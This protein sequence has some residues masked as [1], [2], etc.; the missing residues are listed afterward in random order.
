MTSKP[1]LLFVLLLILSYY[2]SCFSVAGDTLSAGQSLSVGDTLLSQGSKFELGFFSPGSSLK[3]YL[4]I[5]YKFY[6]DESYKNFNEKNAVWV[7]NRENPLS[8]PS[9][10]RLNLSEDGNLLL[11]GSSS[12][13]PF[14]STNLTFTGSNLT[15]AVLRDD[16]NFVLRDR[17]NPS[18]IFWESFDHPTDTW[19]PGAKL[20]ID[21]VTGKPKQLISWKNKEDPAPGVFSF[22]LDP[23]GSNQYFLE[24]NRSQIYWSSGVWN[25]KTQNFAFVP[26]L[27]SNVLVL[28]F[29]FV[30]NENETYFTYYLYDPS[31][32]SKFAMKSTGNIQLLAWLSGP[33]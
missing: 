22:G 5:W 32:R 15:E 26:E 23:N 7:A 2:T 8:D 28:N 24:W 6:L 12:N 1:W 31:Y 25:G 4:G 14:W 9:S 3:F 10:L 19:L 21:K 17:S 16:G 30:S 20:G 18:T 29:S 33:L 13:I 11:F 27:T